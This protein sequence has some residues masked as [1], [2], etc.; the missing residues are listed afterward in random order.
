MK[1]KQKRM[2]KQKEHSLKFLGA[3]SHTRQRHSLE[4]TVSLLPPEKEICPASLCFP[5]NIATDQ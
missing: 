1:E 4:K 2:E 5:A 3:K